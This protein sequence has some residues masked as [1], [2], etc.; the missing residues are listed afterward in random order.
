MK[1]LLLVSTALCAV[2]A[3]LAAPRLARSAAPGPTAP[4]PAAAAAP[5]P[6]KQADPP[7]PAPTVAAAAA[8][9]ERTK[10]PTLAAFQTAPE[11]KLARSIK[12]CKAQQIAEWLRIRCDIE[13]SS[14]S[15]LA[16]DVHDVAFS[17]LDKNAAFSVVLAVRP[18]DRRVIQ[19]N[20]F[21]SFSRWGASEAGAAEISEMWLPGAAAPVVVVN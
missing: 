12:E 1:R 3:G 14:A 6:E 5:I 18:G 11:I 4:I 2:V 15:L 21:F 17:P 10:K 7:S 8:P 16:G 20:H 19:L 13:V 9:A